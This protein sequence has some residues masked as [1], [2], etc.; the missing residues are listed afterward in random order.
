MSIWNASDRFDIDFGF[1][2][3]SSQVRKPCTYHVHDA[4]QIQSFASFSTA[5]AVPLA[6]MSNR[7]DYYNSLLN[8]ITNN[9]LSKLQRMCFVSGGHDYP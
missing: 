9:D 2:Q 3:Y 6:L 1:H 8:Y 7:L 5:Y 4:S